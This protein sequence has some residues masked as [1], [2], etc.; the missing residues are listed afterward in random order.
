MSV[1]VAINSQ[2]EVIMS[3]ELLPELISLVKKSEYEL[4]KGK[5]EIVGIEKVTS[6]LKKA[7]LK[8]VCYVSKDD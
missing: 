4:N 6:D 1:L 7:D 5:I 3:H 8:H 2:G